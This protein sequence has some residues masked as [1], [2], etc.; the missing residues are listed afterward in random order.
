MK[1]CRLWTGY[2]SPDG[3][4]WRRVKMDGK[5][6]NIGVHRLA[7]IEAHGP[8]PFPKAEAMHS[9][10]VPNCYEPTHLS[11]GSRQDN[12]GDA[13]KKGRMP[14]GVKSW[15]TTMTEEDIRFIR[16]TCAMGIPKKDLADQYGVSETQIYR[17]CSREQ[18]SHVQ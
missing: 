9:C 18:W 6:R 16:S 15:R 2:R 4:G 5:W 11:W 13:A 17:I 10:D 3:Y 1:P 12:M 7:C 8:P 14:R